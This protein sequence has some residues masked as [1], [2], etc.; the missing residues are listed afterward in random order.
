M[1]FEGVL[2]GLEAIFKR[3]LIDVLLR[4]CLQVRVSRQYLPICIKK[5]LVCIRKANAFELQTIPKTEINL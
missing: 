1:P 4:I 5:I 3:N 2:R